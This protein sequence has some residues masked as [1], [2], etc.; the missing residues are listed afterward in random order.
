MLALVKMLV[1]KYLSK[2]VSAGTASIKELIKVESFYEWRLTDVEQLKLCRTGFAS[3]WAIGK[4]T[5]SSARTRGPRLASHVERRTR[6]L[7][8]VRISD[9]RSQSFNR[10]T[11]RALAK[12]SAAARL[13]MTTDNGKEFSGFK[14][15]KK[16]PG[17]EGLL[18]SSVHQLETRIERKHQWFD[19]PIFFK[20]DRLFKSEPCESCL[21]G[22]KTEH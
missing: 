7:K 20:T 14:E 21:G 1:L 9:G 2:G 13:T 4:A 5:P 10:G 15:L 8:L 19:P 16:R 6:Y 17:T 11:R 12:I 3:A 18:R 22:E